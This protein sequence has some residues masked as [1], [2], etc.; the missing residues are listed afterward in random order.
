M[1]EIRATAARLDIDLSYLDLNSIRLSPGEDFGVI[2]DDEDLKGEDPLEFKVG[3]GNIIVMDNLPVVPKDKFDKLEV[4]PKTQKT[5]VGRTAGKN[6][7][8]VYETETFTLI[9]KK[10]I[11]VENIM[12]FSWSPTAIFAPELGGGN[13]PARV[14]LV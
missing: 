5:Y 12:D 13:Q 7:I 6:V 4:D 1:D 9:D 10:F 8:S 11:K 14:S 3:F 2:S